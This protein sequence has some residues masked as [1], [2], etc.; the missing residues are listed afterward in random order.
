MESMLVFAKAKG[1]FQRSATLHTEHARETTA[2]SKNCPRYGMVIGKVLIEDEVTS[3][4]KTRRLRRKHAA[5]QRVSWTSMALY[6]VAS[7]M[8]ITRST[9]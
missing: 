8:V 5:P 6:Q 9:P 1:R 4:N 3:Y 2:V 7:C